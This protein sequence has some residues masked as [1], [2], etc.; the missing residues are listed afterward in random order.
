MQETTGILA[1]ALQDKPELSVENKYPWSV[2]SHLAKSRLNFE[3]T[4]QPIQLSEFLQYCHLFQ[5]ERL[6]A[7]DLWFSVSHID[8]LWRREYA[9][10]Q[11]AEQERRMK[12]SKQKG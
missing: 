3:G 5:I 4:P 1:P 11:A 9:E 6:H 12:K 2:F 8:W 7:Q 10:R